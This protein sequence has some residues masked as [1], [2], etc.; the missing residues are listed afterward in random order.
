MQLVQEEIPFFG[1][2][3][4]KEE[5]RPFCFETLKEAKRA[6]KIHSQ[7]ATAPP[8]EASW[9][10]LFATFERQRKEQKGRIVLLPLCLTQKKITGIIPTL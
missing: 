1:K 3:V 8:A 2:N 10:A 5:C 9:C 7:G 6:G 4:P